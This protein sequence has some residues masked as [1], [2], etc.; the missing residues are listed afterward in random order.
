MVI[1]E[2]QLEDLSAKRE[3]FRQRQLRYQW[4]RH[5]HD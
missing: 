2:Q 4:G 3:A 1:V 5:P